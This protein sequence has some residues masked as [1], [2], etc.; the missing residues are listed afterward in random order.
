MNIEPQVGHRC[1]RMKR[2]GKLFPSVIIG[3]TSVVNSSVV[4]SV[5][6][7]PLWLNVLL[8]CPLPTYFSA[9]SDLGVE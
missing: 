9:E 7:V 2:I 4:F 8:L 1:I 6:S 3:A 5:L